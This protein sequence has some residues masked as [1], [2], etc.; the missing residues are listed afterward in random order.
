ME[1]LWSE[2]R[3]RYVYDPLYGAFYLPDFVWD[4]ITCPELQRLREIRLCNTN[5][6]CLTGG[7]N[8]NRYEHSLG[9]CHL[10]YECVKSWPP[11]KPIQVKEQRCLLLA[12]LLHD[13]AGAAF[14]HSVDYIESRDG[15]KHGAAFEFVALGDRGA[16]YSY[17]STLMEPVFFGML[18]EIGS[19]LRNEEDL[20]SIGQL[21]R[22]E[23]RLGALISGSMDLDN[24]DN[25]YRLAYHIGLV[26]SGENALRLAKSIWIENGRLTVK[27][28]AIDLV[29]DWHELRKRLYLVLLLN[30]DEFAAKCMLSEAIEVAKKRGVHLFWY[31]VDFELL[32][33]LSEVSS[34]TLDI[35]RRL[36][37]GDLYGCLQILSSDKTSWYDLITDGSCREEIEKQLSDMVREANALP[38]QFKSALIAI[39]TILDV[40]K[41]ERQVEVQTDDGDI[42]VVGNRSR[43]VLVGIFLKNLDLNMTNI[44]RLPPSSLRS[45]RKW[46]TEYFAVNLADENVKAVELYSEVNGK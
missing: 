39:H 43:R 30:P 7:A 1:T 42:V 25:V 46:I 15:F 29:K 23:G 19:R 22:G 38:S 27:R 32:K 17:K 21:I 37:R 41:V 45:L 5:S 34:E 20:T 18:G 4:I 31:D 28:D 10:A 40:D 26:N 44:R 16:D 8:I 14:G 13:V 36:M 24:I 12:A 9:T 11:L 35:V 3:A 33:R 2:D 6:L